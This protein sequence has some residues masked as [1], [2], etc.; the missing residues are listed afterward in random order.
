MDFVN[1][2]NSILHW[3]FSNLDSE[4]RNLKEAEKKLEKQIEEKYNSIEYSNSG[5]SMSEKSAIQ[6]KS[7]SL[8][9]ISAVFA[10]N[11]DVQSGRS[12]PEHVESEIRSRDGNICSKCRQEEG[13]RLTRLSGKSTNPENIVL[14]CLN[15]RR[16]RSNWAKREAKAIVNRG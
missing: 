2:L 10:D 4:Y 1:W 9:Q 16:D 14:W 7:Y 11:N 15:C 3:L 5:F 13:K 6:S 8:S 12:L